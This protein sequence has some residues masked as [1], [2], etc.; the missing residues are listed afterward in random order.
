MKY[1]FNKIFPLLMKKENAGKLHF[2]PDL[3]LLG[4]NLG[5]NIFWRFHPYSML[6]IV[7]S[8]NLAQYQGNLMM[9]TCKNDEKPNFGPQISFS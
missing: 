8:C 5:H 2:S 1:Q 4:P 6:D 3:R 7:P 9:Q